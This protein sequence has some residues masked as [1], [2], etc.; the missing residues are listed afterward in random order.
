MV[1]HVN[2]YNQGASLYTSNPTFAPSI[3]MVKIDKSGVGCEKNVL[4]LNNVQ[5]F[6]ICVYVVG[7]VDY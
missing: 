4:S 1:I 3:Y 7:K 6:S 2:V 5:Y